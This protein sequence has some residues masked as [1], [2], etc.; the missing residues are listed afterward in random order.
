MVMHGILE[1]LPF[2]RAHQLL[3]DP[4][5]VSAS[6]IFHHVKCPFEPQQSIIS[7]VF[8]VASGNKDNRDTAQ[9]AR[10]T[11][12]TQTLKRTLIFLCSKP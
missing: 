1:V 10:T 4:K 11:S 8:R 9:G 2:L 5:T 7:I 3:T 6:G 12:E